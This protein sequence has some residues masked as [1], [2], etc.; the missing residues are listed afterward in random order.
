MLDMLRATTAHVHRLETSELI[1]RKLY[2]SVIVYY[3]QVN[4]KFNIER[5]PLL[6]WQPSSSSLY[7]YTIS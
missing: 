5:K 3:V 6:K 1:L 2:V 4:R 7:Y